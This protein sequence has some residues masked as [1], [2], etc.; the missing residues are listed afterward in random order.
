MT[1]DQTLDV[2]VPNRASSSAGLKRTRNGSLITLFAPSLALTMGLGTLLWIFFVLEG[3]TALFTDSDTGWH[4]VNGGRII[5]TG[6]L[7]HA[8]PF[9][10]SKPREPWVAWEWGSD[11]LMST[12]YRISGLAGVALMFGVCIGASVFIW[13]RL[14]AIAG[15]TFLLSGLFFVP[16]LPTTTLHWLARP[17]IF[18]WLFLLVTVCLCEQMPRPLLWRH[19][20]F[21]AIGAAAWANL[22]ASFFFAPLIALIYAAGAYLKP[23]IWE[24][25]GLPDRR[26]SVSGGHSYLLLTLA[27]SIGT[28][29][30]PSGWRLHQHVFSY[31]SDAGLIDRISEFQSFDFHQ[32]GATQVLFTITICFAGAFA[33]LAA[34]K[35]ERF[36]LS[37]LLTVAALRSARVLPVAALLL[38]P[39]ANGSLTAVLSRALNLTRQFRCWL[40]GV[41]DY[42]N[43]LHAIDRR[44]SG[45]ALVPLAAVLIFVSV[46]SRAG[47]P[48]ADFPVAA[49]AKVASLPADAR[50]LSPDTFG[51]YLI[52]RFNGERK[53]FADGRSDFYGKEFL[54]RYLRLV[55]ARDGWRGEFN[56]W[57]FTHALLPP[58][59]PLILALE[60]NGWREIYRD[61]TAVLLTGASRL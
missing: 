46:G 40:D 19:L 43:R 25:R 20:A 56:R 30:N 36:L 54:K 24:A 52:Y 57:S 18:S 58:G 4:I 50:I 29:A 59:C 23:L 55:E 10:F 61:R 2:A 39:L 60:A 35:P 22:H 14:N 45:F 37:M 17:H 8:D 44:L 13:F 15:G 3:A 26:T 34:Q 7:P 53:V 6:H 21:V 5:T 31:L 47:F 48:T 42:G 33:A 49:S 27:A 28:L 32:S 1:P 38:L 12:V 41:V 51:G 9:S 11:V 16:M